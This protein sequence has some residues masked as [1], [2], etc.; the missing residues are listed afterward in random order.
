MKF[1]RGK[2]T[3]GVRQTTNLVW[4]RDRC[5]NHKFY[6]ILHLNLFVKYQNETTLTQ[7]PIVGKK[8]I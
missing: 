1:C 6:I 3:D 8:V 7:V 5:S 2:S 4:H